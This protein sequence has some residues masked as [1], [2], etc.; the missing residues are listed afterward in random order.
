MTEEIGLALENGRISNFEG[1]VTLTLD[2]VILHTVVHHSSRPVRTYQISLKS[3][4]LFM[5]RAEVSH[6]T[7]KLGQISKIRPAI[8]FRY[9]AVIYSLRI[10]CQLPAPV[11]NGGWDSFWKWPDFQLWRARDLDLDRVILHTISCITHR[12]LPTYQISLE[13][14]TFCGRTDGQLRRLYYIDYV[15]ES[16]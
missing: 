16:T 10:G 9:C 8:Q 7:Q 6:V 2:R 14:K 1:I 11:V 4:K 13:S 15:E 5:D 3:K 12:H